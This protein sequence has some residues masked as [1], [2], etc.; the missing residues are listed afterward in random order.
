MS[1][2]L[3]LGLALVGLAATLA[4]AATRSPSL[5]EAVVACVAAAS[6]IALGAIGIDSA[7]HAAG[8]LA[9]TIGFLAALLLLA[10][11]CRREG[12]FDALG[13]IMA[14]GSR[15]DPRRLLALVFVVA[16][17]VTV[18]LSLDPT[19]VLVT[20]LVFATAMRLRMGP[21]PYVYACSHLANSASLLLPIS[22]LTNLLAFHASG[23]S[24][25]HFAALM[26]L[27]T[28]AAIAV[29]WVVMT[30]F[31]AAELDR[32]RDTVPAGAGA[33]GAGAARA[34]AA[35]AETAGAETAGAETAALALPRFALVVLGATLIGFL[36]SSPLGIEPVFIALAGAAAITLPALA[37]KT[38]TP[39]ALMHA[40]QPSFLVFVLGL[41]I[42][43]AAASENGLSTAV[44]SV[45]P[46]GDSLLDLLCI[47]VVSAV[48]ANL[49]N[50]L[51]A[52]LILAP[53]AATDGSGAV[54][55]ALIGVNLG[56]NLTYVGSLATLLWRRILRAESTEVDLAE[57]LRLGAITVPLGLGACTLLLWLGMKVAI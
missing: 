48:L 23:L 7:R 4:V 6:L 19:I 25:T 11:G 29:E 16:S 32:P 17:S 44:H 24:F 52:I 5:S 13:A 3:A 55:A 8:G 51:P 26:A 20:P 14:R 43:V 28:A 42:I 27:P 41:G 1:E 34:G 37:R 35:R 36:L 21:K 49:L 31:F 57:F 53:I 2:T 40:A 9:S 18:T 39:R 38:A 54:L 33:A 22:N 15:G 45:L 12:L 10:D 46:A 56:P 47:A 50:N 30:R